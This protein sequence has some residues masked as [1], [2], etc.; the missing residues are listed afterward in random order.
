MANDRM[1]LNV[2]QFVTSERFRSRN[3]AR[4]TQVAPRDRQTHGEGLRLQYQGI[5]D[6]YDGIAANRE[7]PVTDEIGIYIEVIGQERIKLPLEKLDNTDFKLCLLKT[8]GNREVATLFIPEARRGAFLRKV[9]QYLDPDK[10][11]YKE[12][13]DTYYPANHALI[14]SIAEV[15][16]ARIRSFWTDEPGLFPDDPQRQV[17]WELWLKKERNSDPLLIGR[18]LAER[19]DAE[20][21]SSSLNFFKSVVLLIKCS[22]NQLERAPELIANLEELRRAKDTPFPIVNSSP[23]DQAQWV[24]DIS[25][26]FVPNTDANCAVTILDTGINYHHRLLQYVTAGS[27]SECWY[28]EWPHYSIQG[29]IEVQHGSM[30]AGLIAFGNLLDVSQSRSSV[31]TPFVIESGRI[32][33]PTGVNPPELYGDITVS[34]AYK[35]ETERPEYNR[36]FSLAITSPESSVSGMPSSWSAEIDR[37][38]CGVDEDISRLFVISA[39]N[40]RDVRHDSDYWDQVVLSPIEDPA[41]SWNALTVGAY[42]ELSTI[43]DPA[44]DGWTAF[45]MPGDVSPSSRSSVNWSWRKQAPHKPDVV[46][47]GGNHV[48]SPDRTAVDNCSDVSLLTTSGKTAGSAFESHGDTSSAC[49]LITRDAALLRTQYPELWPETIRG[50][51]VHSAEWTPRMMMRFGQLCSQHS[52]GVAKDCLLRTVGHG[53]PDINRARYSADHALTLIAESELQPFIKESN[54]AASAD[55]KNNMMNLHQ[56]PWPVAA[57][58]LLSPETPVKMRVTL[59]YFIEPNP[60]RRGYRSR[61]SYQSHGLRFTTIR[62]GQTLE[63]FRSMVNG[64]AITD[65]YTGPEGDN[66]GWFLGPQL[67]T[68]G[69][70]HSDRWNGSV[71]ELLDM[72]TIAVFPVSGWWKYRSGEDRWQNTVKY[73]LLISIEVPD[74]SVNIYTE[75]ENIVDISVSI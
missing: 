63:N 30:Q 24:D 61:Y 38:T 71:A 54:A 2:R 74:E 21:G 19:L 10:D 66:E 60:G 18:Q 14:A 25:Q 48:I 57:L 26:R 12:S 29:G 15:R 16:F 59:S 69:S 62:P 41:Q 27:Y 11:R 53:V 64:L 72:H 43:D 1:H 23:F 44:F 9:N 7:I 50:L 37:F 5:L 47:E 28:P 34:T 49:A 70:V 31:H 65:D 3:T 40:N 46:A 52:P 17:W 32:I 20:L 8:E 55:P 73:S 51:I 36:V 35:H 56:L 4:S 67:R 6:R 39:G 75:V 68:R 33:P 22:L 42:T 58:Q 45:A 13:E